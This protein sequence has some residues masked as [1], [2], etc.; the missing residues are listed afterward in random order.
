MLKKSMI[1]AVAFVFALCAV[2]AFAEEDEHYI[3]PDDYFISKDA[4]KDQDWI[5]VNLSKMQEAPKKETKGEARFMQ[6]G[7]GK[8]V[9]TKY[10]WKTRKAVKEDFKIGAVVI[11]MDVAGDESIYRAPE[12]KDEA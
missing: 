7:D 6:V 12:S 3:Q 2:P 5:H 9:W 8:S 1:A 11:M 10:Y 4:F